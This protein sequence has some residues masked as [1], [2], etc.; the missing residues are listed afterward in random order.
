VLT[1]AIPILYVSLG[2]FLQESANQLSGVVLF[3]ISMVFLFQINI[4]D[5]R[6]R[7]I[8]FAAGLIPLAYLIS[9]LVNTVD[10]R[11]AWVGTLGRHYGIGTFL[12]LAIIFVASVV[13]TKEKERILN[14]GLG[15][16][17]FFAIIYGTI[18]VAGI[19]PMPWN[20]PF[21]GISL[22]LGNPNFAGALLGMLIIVPVVW[23]IKTVKSLE[24]IGC[25]GL[26]AII[27][28]LGYK[29]Y[30]IQFFALAVINIT[31]FTYLNLD[32]NYGG[33]RLLR[34]VTPLGALAGLFLLLNKDE[35]LLAKAKDSFVINA[36]VNQRLDFWRTGIE[37]WKD[38]PVFGVGPDQ[39]QNYAGV[40]RTSE[41]LLRD[42]V[43]ILPDKAHNVFIDYLAN[44]GLIGGFLWLA[45]TLYI[46]FIILRL[47]KTLK[48]RNERLYCAAFSSIWFAYI[49]QSLISPDQIIL[50]SL[51]YISAGLVF[52]V[53][54]NSR[55]G[56]ESQNNSKKRVSINT[57][58]VPSILLVTALILYGQYL[59]YSAESRKVLLSEITEPSQILKTLDGWP[60]PSG[61]ESLA[62]GLSQ[63]SSNCVFVES[64][65]QRL[66]KLNDRSSQARFVDAGCSYSQGNYK[67]AN[68]Q[69][70]SALKFDPLNTTYLMGQFQIQIKLNNISEAQKTLNL[71]K[72]INPS[73]NG[74]AKMEEELSTLK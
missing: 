31:I 56:D 19:D 18:Q 7:K 22:S 61:L 41:Q 70:T 10:M 8:S 54:L 63:N 60:N 46:S 24:K 15:L 69:V 5:R 35:T 14:L 9:A 53:Y 59:F 52:G 58:V 25:Y 49:A 12:A 48:V 20:N 2:W 21:P 37:I 32:N 6:Y 51:G 11:V 74:L 65:T 45:S 27:A 43:M 26:L 50:T 42:G 16:T 40:H 17:I 13:L 72:R 64:L 3:F 1:A 39:F 29:T 55:S 62:V 47:N 38:H 33:K 36:N 28:L 71:V 67:K 30:S 66:I 34:V 44:A 57:L 68:A 4:F 73:T 23:S